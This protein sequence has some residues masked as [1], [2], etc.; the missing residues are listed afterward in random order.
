MKFQQ[1]QVKYKAIIFFNRICEQMPSGASGGTD[2]RPI[3]NTAAAN[4]MLFTLASFASRLSRR[5]GP[6]TSQQFL[7]V[8]R[9]LGDSE[10]RT[11]P[12]LKLAVGSKFSTSLDASETPRNTHY[13]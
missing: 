2:G 7:T 1:M 8:G 13:L 11:L 4:S 10:S 9:R 6:G 5:H 3:I 12:Q